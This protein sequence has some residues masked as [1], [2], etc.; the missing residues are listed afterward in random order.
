[1]QYAFILLQGKS[2]FCLQNNYFLYIKKG[3][4]EMYQ[5]LS[6]DVKFVERD[7]KTEKF[8]ADNKFVEQSL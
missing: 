1:M 2:I 6:T 7:K 8:G 4:K 5:K 3:G